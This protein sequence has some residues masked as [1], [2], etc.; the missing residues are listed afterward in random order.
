[1]ARD[2]TARKADADAS[3][4]NRRSYLKLVGLATAP[5]VASGAATDSARAATSG[6]GFGEDGYGGGSYGG[7]TTESTLIVKTVDSTNITAS[8]ATLNGEVTDLGGASSADV[9]FEIRETNTTTW[10]TT[11][12]KTLSATGSFSTTLSDLSSGTEYEYR[13]VVS[14]SDGDTTKG[15]TLAFTTQ[16]TTNV[17]DIDQFSVSE[18]GSPNPHADIS[19]EWTVSDA[20]ADLQT[21][22]IRVTNASGQVVESTKTIVGGQSASGTESFKI[23][24][25]GGTTYDCT[26]TVT[27]AESQSTS[28]T[29]SL[30]AS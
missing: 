7:T 10:A 6:S 11:S 14:A 13:A 30:T 25:G 24:R 18:S 21:V 9:A 20:D 5:V 16:S 17:P 3:L 29:K 26:L 27:D 1:M 19:A 28:Q 8:A 22:A 12:S 2:Q 15:T 23:K 4:H